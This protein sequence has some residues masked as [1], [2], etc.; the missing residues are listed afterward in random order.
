MLDEEPLGFCGGGRVAREFHANQRERSVQ[1]L[2]ME[3]ELQLSSSQAF[4]DLVLFFLG[5]GSC[6]AGIR[7]AIPQ[8]DG[9]TA[10]FALRDGSLEG[11]VVDG[12]ILYLHRKSLDRWIE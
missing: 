11:V 5:R 6:V 3:G 1:P 7:S 2:T 9:A 12:M 8:H 4:A 10:V